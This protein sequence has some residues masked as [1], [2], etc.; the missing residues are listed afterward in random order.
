LIPTGVRRAM[1][2]SAAIGQLI[3]DGAWIGTVL[4]LPF[5]VFCLYDIERKS[6]DR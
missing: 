5:L 3:A 4:L 1:A 6:L 2:T